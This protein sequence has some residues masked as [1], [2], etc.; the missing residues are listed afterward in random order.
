MTQTVE[1]QDR[2]ATFGG[3]A[4]VNPLVVSL[5]T[6][7]QNTVTLDYYIA[8]GSR[9]LVIIDPGLGSNALSQGPRQIKDQ[10]LRAGFSCLIV[11]YFGHS[12]APA[13]DSP[14]ATLAPQGELVENCAL[15]LD[16]KRFPCRLISSGS[17][18]EFTISKLAEDHAA[19]FQ[20]AKKI[21][22]GSFLGVVGSSLGAMAG[23]A[24]CRRG[25]QPD[26]LFLRAPAV[27]Y[28]EIIA[29]LPVDIVKAWKRTGQ[30]SIP[31]LPPV[32]RDFVRD[33]RNWRMQDTVSSVTCPTTIVYA[34]KDQFVPPSLVEKFYAML[35]Q[36]NQAVSLIQYPD[37]D[38]A[39]TDRKTNISYAAESV[40][41]G[42]EFFDAVCGE[43]AKS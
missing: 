29:A 16:D 40:G 4:T 9:G 20:W 7:S 31:S 24:G 35:K 19:V 25:L 13:S 26:A 42:V 38:H 8:I 15:R 41:V 3:P 30:L 39:F 22:A 5:K 33:A 21:A 6:E 17:Y 1:M 36:S 14:A 43:S 37:V 32:G 2:S 27:D 23:L 34:G 18:K 11:N 10:Y 28:R 12:L